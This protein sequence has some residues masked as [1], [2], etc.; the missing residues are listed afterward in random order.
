MSARR[1][2]RSHDENSPAFFIG[3]DGALAFHSP[4]HAPD[5]FGLLGRDAALRRALDGFFRLSL[6][7]LRPCRPGVTGRVDSQRAAAWQRQAGEDAPPLILR[8]RAGD[9]A[10]CHAGHERP[11]V[12]DHQIDFVLAPSLS[13]MNRD[14][15]RWE[16]EDQPAMSN[17][18]MREAEHVANERAI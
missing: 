2:S 16:R 13:G 12:I 1:V 10:S 5:G 15:G 18:N 8:F 3:A 6:S 4:A 14:L 11:Y 17:V 9:T 7:R